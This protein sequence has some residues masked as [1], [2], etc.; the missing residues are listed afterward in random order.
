ML[1]KFQTQILVAAF[2][3][4][5]AVAGLIFIHYAVE[6]RTVAYDCRL[7]EISP[8]FPIEVREQCRKLR[9]TSGRI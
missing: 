7:S 5:W 6:N 1:N 9:A 3:I 8:D 2:A 4:V